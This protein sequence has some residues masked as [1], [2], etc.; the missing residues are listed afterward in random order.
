MFLL[1]RQSGG[2]Y[3][4][5]ALMCVK[6]RVK[7]STETSANTFIDTGSACNVSGDLLLLEYLVVTT[8]SDVAIAII[9]SD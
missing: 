2:A 4:T 1:Q 9:E 5:Q 3:T 6:T 8:F 7:L